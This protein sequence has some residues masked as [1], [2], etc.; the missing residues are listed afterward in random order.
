MPIL[1]FVSFVLFFVRRG[2]CVHPGVYGACNVFLARARLSGLT[3]QQFRAYFGLIG[4]VW[5]RGV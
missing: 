1:D 4:F 3:R 2:A 5:V